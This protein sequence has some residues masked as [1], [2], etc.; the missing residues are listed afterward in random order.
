MTDKGEE[1]TTKPLNA[2]CLLLLAASLTLAQ[3]GAQNS[4]SEFASRSQ[5]PTNCQHF[6]T[7]S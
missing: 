3:P 6:T 7:H 4:D 5:K 2:R 1:L